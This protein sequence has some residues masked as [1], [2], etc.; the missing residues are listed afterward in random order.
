MTIIGTSSPRLGAVDRV[1]GAQQYAADIRLDNV[2]HVK[3]VSLACAHA[4]I[5]SI[6]RSEAARAPGVRG[7]FTADDLPQPVPRYGPVYADRPMLATG[8]TKFSGEPVA[9]VVADTRDAAEAAARLVRI[10]FEEL[11]AVLSVDAALDPNAPLVQD[12]ALRSN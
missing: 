7:I 8:E 11:P 3:L 5:V 6:D 4:R 10:E 12:A 9:V 2:L 1:T